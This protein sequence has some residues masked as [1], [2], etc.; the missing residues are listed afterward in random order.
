MKIDFT[1][2]G[3]PTSVDVDPATPLLWV[4]RD[5]LK[6]TATKF[7][8][9]MAMCGACTLHIDGE[10][11]RSCSVPVESIAG[12]NITT[13]E[14]LS[15]SPEKLH[16]IQ[17][18]WIEEQVP[19]CGYCQSGFMMA[20]AKLLKENPNPSEADIANSITNICRCGTQPRIIK[21]IKRAAEISNQKS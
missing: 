17:Q 2:N 6:L 14:G 19:Q 5:E 11:T 8:C 12:K 7:G 1:I 18:A 21:A 10:A 9:G 20:A 3:K 13:L 15:E 16:P 4:V